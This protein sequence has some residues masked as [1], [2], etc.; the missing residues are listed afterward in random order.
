MSHKSDEKNT[1]IKNGQK[2][3]NLQVYS[4][5]S[6]KKIRILR[7]NLNW[8]DTFIAIY[9]IFGIFSDQI[10]DI[11]SKF[12]SLVLVSDLKPHFEVKVCTT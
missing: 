11:F 8:F 3:H 12:L 5:Y 6:V 7:E 10:L 2:N 1:Q 4:K 9:M